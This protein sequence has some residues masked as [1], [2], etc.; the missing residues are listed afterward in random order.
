MAWMTGDD[1]NLGEFD[2]GSLLLNLFHLPC[3]SILFR[4]DSN[5]PRREK[6]IK[7]VAC[8]AVASSIVQE[9]Q[10]QSAPFGRPKTTAAQHNAKT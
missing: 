1:P 8:Q 10:M 7:V 4:A 3:P 9:H 6:I 5:R 2:L